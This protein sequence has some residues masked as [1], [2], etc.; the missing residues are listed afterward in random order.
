MNVRFVA[1]RG[2][3]LLLVL[4]AVALVF[5][6]SYAFLQSNSVSTPIG[7]NVIGHAKAR[8]IAESALAMAIVEVQRNSDWR[9]DYLNGT[10]ITDQ[11]Y[12]GATF[13]IRGE[14]GQDI[15]GDSTISIP[16]EGDGDL[17]D[18]ITDPLTLIAIGTYNGVTHSVKRQLFFRVDDN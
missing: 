5:T 11:P 9:T 10:W 2:I 8:N 7:Q 16:T 18:E 12:A 1:P 3:A 13:T 17:A 15:D 6:L 14:D 4:V